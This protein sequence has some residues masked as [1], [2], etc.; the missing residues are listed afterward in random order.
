[1]VNVNWEIRVEPKVATGPKNRTATGKATSMVNMDTKK[2]FTKS[3]TN[4]LKNFSH[5]EANQTAKITG[6]T[7]PV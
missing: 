6:I 7:V 5:F 3:G 4:L 1:M 2:N